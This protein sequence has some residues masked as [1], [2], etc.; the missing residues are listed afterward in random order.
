MT[1]IYRQDLMTLLYSIFFMYLFHYENDSGINTT[2][3]FHNAIVWVRTH[4]GSIIL[5][6]NYLLRENILSFVLNVGYPGTI[7]SKF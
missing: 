5:L 3:C 4:G 2:K 1:I 7:K 6:F